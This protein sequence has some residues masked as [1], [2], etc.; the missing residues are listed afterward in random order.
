MTTNLNGVSLDTP[1]PVQTQRTAGPVISP[2]GVNDPAAIARQQT[3]SA[4]PAT[5]AIAAYSANVPQQPKPVSRASTQPSS[6]FAAQ[7]IAQGDALSDDDLAVFAPRTAAPPIPAAEEPLDD[8]LANM[9][10]ARGDFSEVSSNEVAAAETKGEVPQL[11]QTATAQAAANVTAQTATGT[12]DV[13]RQT[14]GQLAA[15]LPSLFNKFIRRQN[16]TQVKGVEAYQYAAARN[17]VS[18][19][20]EPAAS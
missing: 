19:R 14:I 4:V 1:L 3:V 18:L 13:E 15:A 17:A 16:I 10:I 12:D 8:Y 20:S 6:Q 9:R 11:Q 2:A 7:A 5:T